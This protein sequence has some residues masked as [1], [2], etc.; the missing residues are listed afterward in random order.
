G[1]GNPIARPEFAQVEPREV[2]GPGARTPNGLKVASLRSTPLVVVVRD[3]PAM[4]RLKVLDGGGAPY[5]EEVLANAAVT[6]AAALPSPEVSEAVLHSDAFADPRAAVAC[7]GQLAEAL[8]QEFTVGDGHGASV[9]WSCGRALV[10]QLA[11]ITGLRIELDIGT[12]I[13]RFDFP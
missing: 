13:D 8:L 2:A 7:L 12:E 9:A 3:D 5:V 4:H 6:G 11:A 1:H 10:P